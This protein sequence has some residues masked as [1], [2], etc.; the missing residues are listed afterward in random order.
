MNLAPAILEGDYVAFCNALNRITFD[1]HFKQ[2]QIQ[3]QNSA[4]HTV[5]N[6]AK[7][8]GIDA[9]G[10]SSMGPGCFSFTREPVRA[11]DWLKQ[12][13]RDGIVAD[14]WFARIANHPAQVERIPNWALASA[15]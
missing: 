5:I 9:I 10:M 2:L 6:E 4:V 3:N 1:T 7:R 12:M 13:Q 14:Y 11:V 15:T 8:N